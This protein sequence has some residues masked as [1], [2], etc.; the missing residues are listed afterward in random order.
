MAGQV[1]LLIDYEN[2]HWS[3][4]REYHLEPELSKLLESLKKEAGK[5]GQITMILAYA[6]FDHD[7]FRGLQSQFQRNNVE[8]RHVFSKTYEDGRRKNAADIEMSLDAQELARDRPDIES[9]V[10]VCGDRDF[11]PVVK[12]LQQ[13]GRTVHVIGIRVT[14]SRDLQ[15]FVGGRYTAVE[16]LLGIIPA[17]KGP[18]QG[19]AIDEGIS[20]ETIL[21]KL[22]AAEQRLKFVAVSHFLNN[23]VEGL[24]SQKSLAFNK[25]VEQGLIELRQIPNPRSADHPTKCCR[26]KRDNPRV[27]EF[28]SHPKE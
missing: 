7:D 10:L 24:F 20:I 17:K 9:F 23:I 25:A 22:D 11:I 26:L 8:T 18:P 5:Y 15:N 12:R 6:D 3:M 13:K 28:L 1:V 14:T 2:V 4:V 21:S 27:V 16:E 19:R